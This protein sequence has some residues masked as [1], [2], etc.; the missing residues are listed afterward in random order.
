[1]KKMLQNCFD[2]SRIPYP[3]PEV[4]PHITDRIMGEAWGYSCTRVQEDTCFNEKYDVYTFQVYS[5][6]AAFDWTGHQGFTFYVPMGIFLSFECWNNY[7]QN[8]ITEIADPIMFRTYSCTEKEHQLQ[9]CARLHLKL[10][11]TSTSRV[12][13]NIG[14]CFTKRL[15]Q[16]Y[17]LLFQ[18]N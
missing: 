2:F 15:R 9:A 4:K 10:S 5:S 1:M 12:G 11:T 8:K 13:Q 16:I 7:L 3:L 18:C 6:V 17:L 14:C